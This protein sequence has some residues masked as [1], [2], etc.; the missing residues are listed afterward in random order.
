MR[1]MVEKRRNA[2]LHEPP[3]A[4]GLLE[5][6]RGGLWDFLRRLSPHG[7]R[8]WIKEKPWFVPITQLLFGNTVYSRSYYDDIER[9]EAASVDR[10]ADWIHS[11]L[12]AKRALDVG[13]GPGHLMLALHRRGIEVVGVD[14]S[15]EAL[16]KVRE[17]GL[18]ALALDLTDPTAA[19]PDGPFDL[20]ISCEVAEH[21][22]RKFAPLFVQ[23]L[24]AAAP[25]VF[26]TAAEPNSALGVGLYHVNEQ[27]NEYWIDL[28]HAQ[29]Y[30][31][32]EAS[33]KS[34]RAALDDPAVIEY[35]RRPMIFARLPA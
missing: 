19:L 29:G 33:T 28:M 4:G 11:R 8:R 30:G 25:R 21:L 32:D 31:L 10:I 16:A 12:G 24:T 17:K 14:L 2:H 13:C 20:A 1:P 15:F 3:R 23:R 22:D 26:L 7:L 34:A 35:L 6:V 5:Q 27:P 18:R 9:I